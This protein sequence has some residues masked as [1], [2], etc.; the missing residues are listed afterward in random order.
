M[1]IFVGCELEEALRARL[2]DVA[3]RSEASL[4]GLRW[5]TPEAM[6]ITLKFLG[7][8]ADELVGEVTSV[9]EEPLGGITSFAVSF[10]GLGSFP[11]RGEPRILW[12][13]ISRG[14]A[15]LILLSKIVEAAMEPIG[16][17][18]E[19]RSFSPHVTL[20]RV[21]RGAR[22]R[23]IGDLTR[24]GKAATFGSQEVQYVS[25]IRS[26][27]RPDGAVYTPI[28]RWALKSAG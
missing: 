26:V 6:H 27:L 21:K 16:F 23:G 28:H 22:P 24:E 13:G 4:D 1:R 15:E 25:L 8:V 2:T 19:K 17:E 14:V 20:A 12:A 5:V 3:R 10:Q 11:T 7:E 18:R 9:L